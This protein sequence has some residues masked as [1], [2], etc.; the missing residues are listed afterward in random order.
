MAALPAS[1]GVSG[2]AKHADMPAWRGPRAPRGTAAKPPC[3]ATPRADWLSTRP[4]AAS[5]CLAFRLC[6]RCRSGHGGPAAAA[7]AASAPANAAMAA[8][9]A[10]SRQ[11]ACTLDGC[12]GGSAKCGADAL[13]LHARRHGDASRTTRPMAR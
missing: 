5:F 1:S 13:A 3:R 12:A 4:G 2:R 10:R 8:G 9:R 11:D 7:R 6:P